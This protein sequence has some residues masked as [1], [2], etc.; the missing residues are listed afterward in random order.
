MGVV[1]ADVVASGEVTGQ[2]LEA[3]N[4]ATFYDLVKTTLM[5]RKM[6]LR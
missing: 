6:S 5:R 2:F 1:E 4:N 3:A